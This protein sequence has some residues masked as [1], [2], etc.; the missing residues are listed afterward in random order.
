MCAK[1]NQTDK[2]SL[3]K[4]VL[5]S[6]CPHCREGALFI[7]PNP[8]KLKTTMRMYE[9]CPVCGQKYEIE[10]GFFFGTGYISYALSVAY[11]FTFFLAWHLVFGLSVMDSSI[12]QCL[13]AGAFTIVL[14]QPLLQRLSRSIW[15]AIFVHY[16]PEWRNKPAQPKT[17]EA[18]VN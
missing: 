11:L 12:F 17:T 16:D 14:L 6:R 2:P 3:I 1:N 10:T 15:I 5:T 18:A 4:S 8:Y 7:Y 13:A 9:H